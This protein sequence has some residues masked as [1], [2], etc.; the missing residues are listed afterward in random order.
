MMFDR[1]VTVSVSIETAL[2]LKEALN[3]QHFIVQLLSENN[4]ISRSLVSK[5]RDVEFTIGSVIDKIADA[6]D[7]EE[8]QNGSESEP[9]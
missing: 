4:A 2:E 5:L 8:N 7:E 3:M 1:E 9:L 6:I